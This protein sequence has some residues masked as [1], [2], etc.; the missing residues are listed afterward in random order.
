MCAYEDCFCNWHSHTWHNSVSVKVVW[1]YLCS[2]AI[3]DVCDVWA[4]CIYHTKL[5]KTNLCCVRRWFQTLPVGINIDSCMNWPQ[6]R[7]LVSNHS[8]GNLLFLAITKQSLRKGTFPDVAQ[9]YY[10]IHVCLEKIDTTSWISEIQNP[11]G[12]NP[13][14]NCQ[15]EGC[16]GYD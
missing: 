14:G 5:L 8:S 7:N 15:P 11:G 13:G 4:I 1:I 16:T 9:F 3:C 2:W 12:K 10:T 6:G